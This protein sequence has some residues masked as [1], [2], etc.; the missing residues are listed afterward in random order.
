MIPELGISSRGGHGNPL[1]YSW[2]E[3]PHGQKSLG[4]YRPWDRI[5]LD[6]TEVTKSSTAQSS[7]TPEARGQKNKESH[8]CLTILLCAG[9]ATQIRDRCAHGVHP[10]PEPVSDHSTGTSVGPHSRDRESLE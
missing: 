5:E 1:Q 4:G 6:M 2:L 8:V 3:N 9:D 7:G 10:L